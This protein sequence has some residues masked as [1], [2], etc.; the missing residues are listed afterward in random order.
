M[1]TL[2]IAFTLF[3]AG[4]LTILLPCILPL[5]PIVLGVSVAGRS[6]LRPL[7]IVLGMVTGFVV[8]NFAI[9]LLLRSFPEIAGAIRELT[10]YILLLFG[11]GFV[12]HDRKIQIVLA[13]LGG[14]LLMMDQTVP[15]LL[16]SIIF[17]IIAMLVGGKVA[18]RIQQLGT[19][20]QTDV[21]G[22]LGN[23]NLLSAFV[24]GLTL[25]L[26]W[27]PCAGP[28]LAFA[29][30]LVREEPGIRAFIL[31]LIYAIG[32]GLPLLIVGYG[33][34]YAVQSVRK[35]APYTGLIKKIA[36][37]VLVFMAFALKYDWIT[38]A[39]TY[40]AE[41]TFYGQYA[42]KFEEGLFDYMPEGASSSESTKES[43]LPKISLAPEFNSPG[44]WLNS[45][46]LKMADL[47]GKVVL[48][49]FWTYSCINCIR[50]FP[51][52]KGYWEKYKDQPFVLV[53]V[54][55]PEFVFEQQTKNVEAA[56]KKYGLTYPVV[57]DNNYGT[58]NAFNNRYWPAKYLI[59][60]E[61]YIRYYHFGE[62]DYEETDEAIASLLK[63][64]GVEVSG[65]PF[66]AAQDKETVVSDPQKS[67][68]AR[69][70]ET[71]LGARSWPSLANAKGNPTSDEI[72]Y[73]APSTLKLHQYALEGTWQLRED[74]EYQELK[75]STGEIHMKF[76][77]QEINLVLGLAEGV[78]SVDA[79]VWIDGVKIKDFT[80]TMHD[81][82]E[83]Y[84][85][86]GGEHELILKFK[87]KGVEGYA[88]TFG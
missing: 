88:F 27:V 72:A 75:T 82:Y 61:G 56:L 8:F 85:G 17:G 71:Y 7:L 73:T 40:V 57:Q 14:V 70:P 31:L 80:V 63:E 29:L 76:Q 23:D 22:A 2:S 84:K 66:D 21:R 53:G 60:A 28:A 65:Q 77:G 11:I 9:F 42:T 41:N 52:L 69:S 19:T 6:K 46:E 62:G 32:A 47:K 33:G 83:L 58:W 24:I 36:G 50:T 15:F 78:T 48:I 44:P 64:V 49:D 87:S 55:T 16:G 74:G 34:Q 79:E 51:Y 81:L 25:G 13:I 68:G 26:V 1:E 30:T 54:H 10:F 45:P 37:V 20:I 39:Q 3:V 12:I 86:D 4:A 59:D 38:S 18:N 67:G 5:V 35:I 43:S